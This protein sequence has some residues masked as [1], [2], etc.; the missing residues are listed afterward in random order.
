MHRGRGQKLL[1]TSCRYLV[2]LG[3]P[4]PKTS[5]RRL[6]PA[7]ASSLDTLHPSLYFQLRTE[8]PDSHLWDAFL[9]SPPN[10]KNMIRL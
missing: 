1:V 4:S 6:P 5:P 8:P 7:L 3:P 2:E 10:R 9:P